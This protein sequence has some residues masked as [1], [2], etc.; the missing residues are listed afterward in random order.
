[1]GKGQGGAEHG[2][3]GMRQPTRESRR[4]VIRR[5]A[6]LSRLT[7]A[8]QRPP[9]GSPCS[10]A[11]ANGR[12]HGWTGPFNNLLW[13]F[14]TCE[15]LGQDPRFSALLFSSSSLSLSLFMLVPVHR[16]S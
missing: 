13:A 6:L 4:C 7:S 16:P 12:G 5:L 11:N 10:P 3:R 9:P 14:L 1:L 15:G 2:D 8:P